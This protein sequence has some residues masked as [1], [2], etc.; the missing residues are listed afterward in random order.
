MRYKEPTI[1][2]RVQSDGGFVV[3]FERFYCRKYV[4]NQ[5]ISLVVKNN[6]VNFVFLARLVVSL[7]HK[8]MNYGKV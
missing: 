8:W 1:T 4:V 7:H 3:F 6:E 5:S 2:A